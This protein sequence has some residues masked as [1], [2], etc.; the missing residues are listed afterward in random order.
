M[1]RNILLITSDQQRY[2]SLG[3]N[4]GSVA[5]TPILDG[6]AA[7]GLNYRRAYNQNVTCTPARASIL[8]GQ[9]IGT[10]GAISCGR[11]LPY[12]AP[13]IAGYLADLGGYR[14]ALIGKAHFEPAM[15]PLGRLVENRI[16]PAG[17]SGPLRGFEHVELA[18]H[19]FTPSLHYGIWLA[20]NPLNRWAHT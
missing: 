12:D 5:R 11:V 13:T 7:A 6:L 19:G 1:G 17:S 9:Y 4:G 15:D 18:M 3:C 20:T 8:T 16:A 10:H 14:T 2:D